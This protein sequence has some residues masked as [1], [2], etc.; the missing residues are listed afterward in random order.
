[1][2]TSRP[3]IDLSLRAHRW[4]EE[5]VASRLEAAGWPGITRAHSLVLTHLDRGGT[6]SIEVARRMGVTRQA[7]HQT[8][9]DLVALGLLE[10]AADPASHRAKLVVLTRRGNG[11]VIDARRIFRELEDTLEHR[12]GR[13]RLARLRRALES[14]WGAPVA[15]RP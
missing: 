10:L 13:K 15:G 5:A 4:F 6:R 1:L 2:T 12:I 9:R 8:I 3:L 14:D 11:L 7:A